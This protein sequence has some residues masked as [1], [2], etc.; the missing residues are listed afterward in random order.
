MKVDYS[1]KIP[2]KRPVE[3][4]AVSSRLKGKHVMVT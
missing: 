3:K 4:K 1:K 2:I